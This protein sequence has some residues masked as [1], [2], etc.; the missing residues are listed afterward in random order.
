[1]ARPI[2]TLPSSALP[3]A[4]ASLRLTPS[5]FA[6]QHLERWF[7][8]WRL[9]DLKGWQW[10]SSC[11]DWMGCILNPDEVMMRQLTQYYVFKTPGPS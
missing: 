2:A 3:D 5:G 6:A 7:L 8:C 4:T 11:S 1:M 10:C 9:A